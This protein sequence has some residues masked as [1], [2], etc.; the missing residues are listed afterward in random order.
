MKNKYV[1]TAM[2]VFGI[3]VTACLFG[4]VV[5]SIIVYGV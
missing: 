2:Q 4:M 3:I 5:Y 1:Q